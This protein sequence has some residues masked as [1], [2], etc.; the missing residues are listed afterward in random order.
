MQAAGHFRAVPD[1][2]ESDPPDAGHLWILEAAYV[3]QRGFEPVQT[4]QDGWQYVKA[5]GKLTDYKGTFLYN[6]SQLI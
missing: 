2:L 4:E 1:R 6:Q 5:Y 3:R